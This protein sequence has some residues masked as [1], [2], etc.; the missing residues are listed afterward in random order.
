MRF[1]SVDFPDPD[2][3]IMATYSPLRISASTPRRAC[4]CSAPISKTFGDFDV[5]H[6]RDSCLD[7][8][9]YRFLSVHHKH[10]LD[11]VFLRI[12]RGWRRR[13]RQS[14]AR[15][16][17]RVLCSFLEVLACSHRERLNGNGQHIL[18]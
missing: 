16:L 14:H 1:M 10:A 5:R 17:F 12:T 3:P 8:P 18:S 7:G 13:R 2:G 11:L 6:A 9:K 15:L 4:T